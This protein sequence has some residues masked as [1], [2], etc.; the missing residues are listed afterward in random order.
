MNAVVGIRRAVLEDAVPLAKLQ[1]LAQTRQ[2]SGWAEVLPWK[3]WLT[4]PRFFTYIA[5]QS[6]LI[7]A[8][9]VGSV[10]D[11]DL[12]RED[13]LDGKPGEILAWF[14]HPDQWRQKLGRK[15]L[16]HGLTG[17]KRCLFD[18]AVIWVPSSAKR[19][20]SVIHELRFGDTGLQRIRNL[21]SRSIREHC[22]KLDLD[23][24][25]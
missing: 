15:L 24:Y 21:P 22:Y 16:V 5:E 20:R 18:S 13:L 14:I 3:Q 23:S 1:T 19:A 12:V 2:D 17:L 9:A 11:T 10:L 8:V 7:G 25:F 6:E 4:D